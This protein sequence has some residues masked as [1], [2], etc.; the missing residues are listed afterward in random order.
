MNAPPKRVAMVVPF[1]A[2]PLEQLQ[3][4]VR[5]VNQQTYLTE[6]ILVGDGIEA[7]TAMEGLARARG[8]ST[9]SRFIHLPIA[10]ADLGNMARVVGSLEAMV[11]GVD[12]IGFLDADNWLHPEHVQKLLA[13]HELTLADVCTASRKIC[14]GDGSEMFIDRESDGIQH[15]DTSCFL[16]MRPAFGLLAAWAYIPPEHSAISDRLFWSL[17][18]LG[19]RRAGGGELG[20]AHCHEPTVYYRT[21]YA[22]HYRAI[23]EAAPPN[24]KADAAAPKGTFE[25]GPPYNFKWIVR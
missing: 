10:H 4:C 2:E 17:A 21:R 22:A 14:R 3:Q 20:L 13:L 6:L 8:A 9:W 1:H 18:K 5:S 15:V 19:S 7:L 11:S 12:C 16:L 24:A 25:I 23:G